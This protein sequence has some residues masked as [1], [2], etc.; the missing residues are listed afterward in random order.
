MFA[1]LPSTTLT[2]LYGPIRYRPRYADC[3]D[4]AIK[5]FETYGFEKV[6]FELSVRGN[7]DNKIYLG[8]DETWAVV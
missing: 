2:F 6:K 5:V 4:F 1:D 3:L 7:A 8:S